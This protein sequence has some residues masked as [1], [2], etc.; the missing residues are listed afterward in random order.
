M[1]LDI[2][3]SFG[4]SHSGLLENFI[5]IFLNVCRLL[6]DTFVTLMLLRINWNM[7]SKWYRMVLDSFLCY[8]Q[9]VWKKNLSPVLQKRRSY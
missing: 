9:F 5:L 4:F 7:L 3:Y 2:V 1:C 6:S 8:L